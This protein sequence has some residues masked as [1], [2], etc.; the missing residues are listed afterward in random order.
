MKRGKGKGKED[1][2]IRYTNNLPYYSFRLFH[3][4]A[5]VKMGAGVRC[6]FGSR[7]SYC[8]FSIHACIAYPILIYS[9]HVALNG[10][11]ELSQAGVPRPGLG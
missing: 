5:H 2:T 11:G 1:N 6:N 4:L 9:A 8:L 7:V 10:S 3:L